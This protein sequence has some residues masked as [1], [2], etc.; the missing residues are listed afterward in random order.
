MIFGIMQPYFLPYIGYFQLIGAVDTYILYDD[1]KYTKRGWI[2]RNRLL[3][4]G[5][6][7]TFSIPLKRRSDFAEIRHR[8][9]ASDFDRGKL[10][11]QFEG[12]YRL[13]PYF[14]ETFPLLEK[15]MACLECNLFEFLHHSILAI[16]DWLA[17]ATSIRRS[18][19]IPVD[20]GLHGEGKIASDMCGSRGHAVHQRYR[21]AGAL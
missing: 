2:N 18:S 21:R 9:M 3:L 10:L 4:N 14:P 13:A 11:R 5:Q 8:D 1:A 12:A 20:P 15:V 16:C 17:I 19:E 7:D 6:P